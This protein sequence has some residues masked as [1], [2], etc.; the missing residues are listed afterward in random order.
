MVEPNR[1]RYRLTKRGILLLLFGLVLAFVAYD[2]VTYY[3]RYNSAI[4]VARLHGARIG[5]LMDWPFGRECRITFDQ[6]LNDAAFQ[7]L[8]VLNSLTGRHWVGVALNYELDDA[9]LQS[10]RDILHNCHVLQPQ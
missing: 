1:N 7:D 3:A 4:D 9:H 10:A 8:K 2:Y 6:P 5:S